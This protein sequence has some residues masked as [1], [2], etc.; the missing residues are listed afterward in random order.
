MITSTTTILFH[1][2]KT[3]IMVESLSPYQLNSAV[4]KLFHPK[5]QPSTQCGALCTCK[6]FSSF[7]RLHMFHLMQKRSLGFHLEP[8]ETRHYSVANKL[9]GNIFVG[10]INARSSLWGDTR[11]NTCGDI[12]EAYIEEADL[13]VMNNGEPTFRAVNGKSVNDLT[14]TPDKL[15]DLCYTQYTDTET[16]LLTGYPNRRHV[17]VFSV[18]KIPNSSQHTSE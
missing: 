16:E 15:T 10:D 12:L 18:L 11:N 2:S 4:V 3:Q 17:S 6:I 14:I 7:C 5:G 8:D 1:N 13:L 9:S